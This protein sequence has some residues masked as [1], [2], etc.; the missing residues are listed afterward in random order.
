[1]ESIYF[2]KQRYEAQSI[3]IAMASAIAR[4]DNKRASARIAFGQRIF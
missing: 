2:L 4:P 3:F 1:M